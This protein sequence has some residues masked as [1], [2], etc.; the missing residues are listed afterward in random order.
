MIR[1]LI[2]AAAI[3]V[4]APVSTKAPVVAITGGKVQVGDGKTLENATVLIEGDRITAVGS[5]LKAP[6]GAR[7]VDARGKVVAPGF[8]DAGNHL[9]LTEVELVEETNEFARNDGSTIHAAFRVADAVDPASALFAVTRM[10]GVTSAVSMPESGLV[11][12]QSAW[13]RLAGSRVEDL[14]L[15]TPA[16]MHA[17]LGEGARTPGG[18]SRGAALEKIREVLEDARVLRGRPAAFEENRM[19]DLSAS[20][21]DLIALRPVLDR[22]LLLVIRVNRAADIRSALALARD[23]NL[24]IAIAGGAEAWQVA[25]ELASANVPVLLE[26]TMNLPYSFDVLGARADSAAL[27]DAAGV[28]IALVSGETHNARTIRQEAGNAAA[29]GLPRE[30]A[31]AAITSAPAAIFGVSDRVG[32]IAPGLLAD[33]VIWSGDPLELSSQPVSVFVGG[34]ERPLRSRQTELLERY[35][36]LPPQ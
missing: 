9:G 10:E 24:R 11:R 8:V 34:V 16:A 2:V 31:L 35:R 30:K 18:G 15:K 17:T 12:G 4:A 14:L 28:R 29:W 6:A 1:T 33:V 26:P 23:E 32:R 27:L 7:V 36:T 22:T 3:A 25:G 20:R 19:R 13:L 5:G 21:L